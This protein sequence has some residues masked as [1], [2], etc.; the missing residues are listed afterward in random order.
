MT[1]RWQ[2]STSTDDGPRRV[3]RS[4]WLMR[5]AVLALAPCLVLLLSGWGTDDGSPRSLRRGDVTGEKV[6]FAPLRPIKP[7]PD[8]VHGKDG[9]FWRRMKNDGLHDKANPDIKKLR[10][11][12]EHLSKLPGKRDE[13]GNNV[14]WM[15]ALR[16]GKI[17]PKDRLKP[18]AAEAPEKIQADIIMPR[19]AA[20][21]MV[22]FPHQTHTEWL[23]CSNCHDDLFSKKIG[24]ARFNMEDILGGKYCG[25]CHGAVA[26]PPTDCLRCHNAERAVGVAN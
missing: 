1:Q 15:A 26:F 8:L 5:M 22:R 21:P 20:M 3:Q 10:E 14:D 12:A 2:P 7:K 9:R 13:S 16:Q 19:T 25:R 23:S 6:P 11:P 18:G 4:Q 24:A 17:K